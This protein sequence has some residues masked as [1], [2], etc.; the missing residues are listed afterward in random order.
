ML[1]TA[2]SQETTNDDDTR[3]SPIETPLENLAH[4]I[5]SEQKEKEKHQLNVVLH[6]VTESLEQDASNRKSD[7]LSKVTSIFSDHLGVSCSVTNA[8]QIGNKGT[9]LHLL[10]V[11]VSNLHEKVTM[12]QNKKIKE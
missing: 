7:D 12:L 2:T 11:S 8:V 5:L 6:N 4:S 3:S 10:K 9:K 1:N